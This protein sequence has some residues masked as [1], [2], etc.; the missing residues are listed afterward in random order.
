M[1]SFI[2]GFTRRGRYYR[3]CQEIIDYLHQRVA[4]DEFIS[5]EHCKLQFGKSDFNALLHELRLMNA[6]TDWTVMTPAMEWL[7]YSR[8]FDHK[9]SDEIND[10]IKYILVIISSIAAIISAYSSC[11]SAN[12]ARQS[13]DR[14]VESVT[15]IVYNP[16]RAETLGP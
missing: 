11:Q 3:R 4:N 12:A 16:V 9:A 6:D 14:V 7:Y 15:K 1:L 10:C 13:A 5:E 2:S 8:Y